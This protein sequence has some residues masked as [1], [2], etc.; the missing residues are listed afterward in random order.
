VTK[1]GISPIALFIVLLVLIYIPIIAFT[2]VQYIGKKAVVLLTI[3]GVAPLLTAVIQMYTGLDYSVA[4]SALSLV[5]V[6]TNLQ[7]EASRKKLGMLN[8]NL[9]KANREQ[10]SQIEKIKALNSKLEESSREQEVQ[11]EQIVSMNKQ[12]VDD[13]IRQSERYEIIMSMSS[14]YFASYYIDLVNDTYIEFK[15]KESIKEVI[16]NKGKAQ[17]SLNIACEK[18]IVPEHTQLM[19]DFFDLST[20]NER[21]RNKNAVSCE[22]I[23]VTSGWSMAYLIAGDRD[24][25]GN[26][27]HLFYACRTIHDEK[28]REKE[29]ARKLD[30]FSNIIANAGIGVWYILLKDGE[31]PRMKPND[32]MSELLGITGKNLSEEEIYEYWYDR[33]VPKELESVKKSVQEMIDGKFSENTYLW[34]HPKLGRIYVRCGGTAEL[35]PDGTTVLSGYH[36][37]VNDIVLAE[38]KQK[39]ELSLARQE[40]ETASKAKSDFLF[41]MS[42]DIRTPMNAIIGFTELLDKNL[43]DMEKARDYIGKIRSSS[44]FLL[45]LINNVLEVARIESGKSVVNESVHKVGETADEINAVFCERMR[46]KNI[47][48][49]MTVEHRTEYIYVDPVKLKEIYLNIISNA[50]KYTPSGGSVKVEI[51]EMPS[52]R[53]G[54]AVF[55]AHIADTGI[56]MSPE[57]LPHIFDEFSR[58]K[59]VTEDGIEGTGLGMPIVKNLVELMGGNIMVESELG[60]GTVFTIII[61]HRIGKAES[62]FGESMYESDSAILA[63]KR[64]LL[65]EDNELNAEIAVEILSGAGLNVDVAEDG[66]VCLEMLKNA[67]D[68]YYNLI[69][70]DVQMPNLDGYSTTRTIRSTDNEYYR[71][72]PIFAMTANAFEEDKK[73]AADAG[74]NGH[75]AKPIVVGTMLKTLEEALK[76]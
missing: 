20:I 4:A 67:G 16:D 30:E 62:V 39:E 64:I 11:L 45:S 1:E 68:Y 9:E 52:F 48:F 37:D 71:N 69:L 15:A 76:G 27:L 26:L 41:S 51:K 29:Q 10:N 32:K 13:N 44:N 18:L 57:F 19:K 8:S 74:M 61:P 12:L 70:M 66:L 31:K 2:K 40:A 25:D 7:N 73:N 63:G 54:Y 33:I 49:S 36:Y 46:Q 59:S 23:G 75:I 42:H 6:S 47:D 58:E 53:A 21:L 35:R 56:G 3:Y 43:D 5:L 55:E 60:K 22:Y 50:Y 65:A 24:A 72:I 28:E 34:K 17:E 38:K 14:I